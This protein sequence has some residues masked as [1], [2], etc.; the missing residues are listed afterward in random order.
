MA[1]QATIHELEILDFH[2]INIRFIDDS[3]ETRWYMARDIAM[4]LGYGNTDDMVSTFCKKVINSLFLVPPACERMFCSVIP[5]S[6]I[7]GLLKNAPCEE[8]AKRFY[9]WL[10]SKDPKQDSF[11]PSPNLFN[12][13]GADVRVLLHNE[14]GEPWF[15]ARDVALLLGYINISKAIQAHCKG[16]SK[17]ELPSAKGRQRTTIIPERDV[18]R[19]IMRSRL[20]AAE[21][22]EEWVVGE[23]LPSIRKTGS[24]S[25]KPSLPDFSNPV[26]AARAWADEVEAKQQLE[27]ENRTLDQ[28]NRVMKPK[29]ENYDRFLDASGTMTFRE[30]GKRLGVGPNILV[31]FLR[32]NGILYKNKAK[33]PNLPY[34][35]YA[36]KGLFELISFVEQDGARHH[37]A[38]RVTSKGLEFIARLVDE[39]RDRL[40]SMKGAM[41]GV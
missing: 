2:G 36:D 24:Y 41:G 9:T 14:T 20:A 21:R 35:A 16:G 19:L 40:Q 18:Y 27:E 32:T 11:T 34:A 30:V 38:T 39:N 6:E 1:A 13:E 17:M 33:G 3:D 23:V 12:F 8:G 31:E 15:V 7:H 37:P 26:A 22:F 29:A 5:D 25:A 10:D 4:V 28:E